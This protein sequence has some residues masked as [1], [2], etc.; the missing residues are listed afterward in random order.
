MQ[1]SDFRHRMKK[2]VESLDLLGLK[3]ESRKLE[4]QVSH[5]IVNINARQQHSLTLAESDDYPRQ[6]GPTQSTPV[7]DLLDEIKKGNELIKGVKNA[8]SVLN[9]DETTARINAIKARQQHFIKSVQENKKA[10]GGMLNLTL[11]NERALHESLGEAKRLREMFIGTRDESEVNDIVVQLERL[12][13]DIDAWESESVSVER[14]EILLQQQILN[15]LSNMDILLN[16]Q[17]IDPAWD[18]AAIYQAL[19]A[20]HVST[21]QR[22]SSDWLAPRL[23]RADDIEQLDRKQC[24]ALDKELSAAPEYLSESDLVQTEK[25]LDAVRHRRSELDEQVRRDKL[26]TW[27]QKFLSLSNI[28]TIEKQEVEQLLK[29]LRRPPK[30]TL[31]EELAPVQ[32]IETQLIAHLDKMGVDDIFERTK[33]LPSKLQHQL[34]KRLSE[35]LGIVNRFK[36]LPA[37]TQRKLLEKLSNQLDTEGG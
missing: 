2:A 18:M 4:Q 25:L 36:N 35:H 3:P 14:L 17:E 28:E 20:E 34:L 15:Q 29:M 5:S 16:E 27:Q 10:L 12:L 7:R 1:V 24:I 26:N 22:R 30:G 33:R 11:D 9:E 8:R 19:A 13:A 31:P 21:A 32:A 6:P 37:D 23:A